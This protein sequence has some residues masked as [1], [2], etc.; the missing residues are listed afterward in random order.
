MHENATLEMALRYHDIMIT[1]TMTVDK[2]VVDVEE[3]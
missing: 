2:V 3:N 1:P